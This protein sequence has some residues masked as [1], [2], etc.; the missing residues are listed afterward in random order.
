M[1]INYEVL[2]NSGFLSPDIGVAASNKIYV[3]PVGRTF[4]INDFGGSSL[5]KLVFHYM[6]VPYTDGFG[7]IQIA[8]T[9]PQNL[10]PESMLQNSLFTMPFIWT[11]QQPPILDIDFSPNFIQILDTSP[12]YI[13]IYNV[14]SP[15]PYLG[16]SALSAPY[17][18]NVYTDKMGKNLSLV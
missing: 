13:I 17:A 11:N 1:S 6:N 8:R 14:R 12:L 9:L 10:N 5:V 4:L 16:S 3:W 2:S 7:G 18:L 15:S